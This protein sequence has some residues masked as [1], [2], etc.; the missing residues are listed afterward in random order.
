MNVFRRTQWLRDRQA[1]A[2]AAAIALAG[3]AFSLR[4]VIGPA[5]AGFPFLTFF[6]AVLAAAL[7]GGRGPGAAC[8]LLSLALA[9]YFLLP[10]TNSFTV[11]RTGD[12][13]G[14]V[15]FAFVAGTVVLLVDA[16]NRA[17]LQ[18][19]ESEQARAALNEALEKKVE[20]RTGDL[21]EANRQLQVEM[22]ARAEAEEH[23]VQMQR[24]QAVGQL[25]GGIAHDFNNM[26]AIVIGNLDMAQRRIAQ[27]RT[28]IVRYVDN[29][30]D[31]ARR[32]AAL[33]RR[34]LAFARRQAL[35]PVVTDPNTLVASMSELL[36]RTLGE[37]VHLECVLA[38]GLWRTCVDPGQL[39]AAIINLAVNA[40]DAMP[41]GGRLTIETAN[42]FLDDD[43]AAAHS[44]LTAGQYV[45]IAV[46]DTG[47][48][49]APEVVARAFEPFFTTKDVGRGTGLGL[50]QLYGFIKQSGGHTKIYSELGGG[51]TVKLYLPRHV[52]P[53]DAALASEPDA[54]Q[55]VPSGRGETLLVVE[56]EPGV[57]ATAVEILAELGYHILEAGSGEE[58]LRALESNGK[59]ALL[60]TDVV[61]PGM[62]GRELADEASRRRPGLKVLYTTGYTQNAI[63]H[64]GRLDAG[65]ALLP[66][67]YSADQLARKVRM[68]LDGKA[69]SG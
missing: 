54:G 17:Y 6:P 13:I 20:E 44:E 11:E 4:W 46:S 61:M 15:L 68:V 16:M 59:V 62:T 29:A 36:H 64:G 57:R 31:G 66:K 34:L 52:G 55:A 23:A 8:A 19:E 49:M 63:V 9:W 35:S 7:I 65:V 45:M 53:D 3:I 60:F 42:A 1:I 37:R 51:T 58:A 22:A 25:T 39:E 56:D 67:P 28:D 5:L 21:Q 26:L 10:P 2:Y 40:R 41:E 30:L 32:G 33:T 14:V 12:W 69:G 27:G 43:Y 48:G 18:L 47:S 38:A 24:M 50:S